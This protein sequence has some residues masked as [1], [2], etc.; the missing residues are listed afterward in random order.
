MGRWGLGWV[1]LASA[2]PAGGSIVLQATSAAV[3]DPGDVADVCVDL[4]SGGAEVAGT[5][6]DL[7]WDGSCATL[8]DASACRINPASGKELFGN[9]SHQPDFT[10][11]AVVLSLADVDPI[12]DGELYCCAFEVDAPPGS[13]CAINVT[14]PAASDPS[15]RALLPIS[16]NR[17][18]VCVAGDV[19]IAS[20][21]PTP[22]DA[23]QGSTANDGDGCQ[24]GPRQTAARAVL[25]PLG[26]AL[27]LATRRRRR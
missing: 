25:A 4:D 9:V 17:A 23:P 13:C 5:Q 18:E 21:T 16:G 7:V 6:N 3:A 2:A 19:P 10:Y 8:S 12:P 20:P 26:V 24:V 14:N 27:L 1:L 11:R 15:G 22:T